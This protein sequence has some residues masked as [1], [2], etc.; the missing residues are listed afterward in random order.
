MCLLCSSHVPVHIRNASSG[1]E[2]KLVKRPD[3]SVFETALSN[4]T[5]TKLRTRVWAGV[6]YWRCSK[7]V[8][9]YMQMDEGKAG[10]NLYSHKFAYIECNKGIVVKHLSDFKA[11]LD[12]FLLSPWEGLN[13]DTCRYVCQN[14]QHGLSSSFTDWNFSLHPFYILWHNVVQR[15]NYCNDYLQDSLTSG[16][17]A[18]SLY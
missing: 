18:N 14:D 2:E 8:R 3:W 1:G 17:Q 11:C 16:H 12:Y 13:G 9:G 4:W 5:K 10:S 15:A 7:K 6:F